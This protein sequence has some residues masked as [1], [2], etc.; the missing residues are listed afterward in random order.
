MLVNIVLEG[1]MNAPGLTEEVAE[2]ANIDQNGVI[3]ILDIIWLV[4]WIIR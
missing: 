1:G 3:N 2:Q 4:N